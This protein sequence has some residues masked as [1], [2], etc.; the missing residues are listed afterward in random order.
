MK[1][2]WQVVGLV[3]MV[4]FIVGL[5][6]LWQKEKTTEFKDETYGISFFISD[7]YQKVTRED[8][9]PSQTNKLAAHFV[10]TDPSALITVRYETGLRKVKSFSRR[11]SIEHFMADISQFFPVK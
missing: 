8:K 3:V 9:K 7:G 11:S 2:I 4:L 10:R 1:K 5:I 6:V